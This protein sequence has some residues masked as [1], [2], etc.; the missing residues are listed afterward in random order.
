MRL[1]NVEKIKRILDLNDLESLRIYGKINT[2]GGK[3]IESLFSPTQ[4]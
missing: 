2:F 4:T 3:T 1:E